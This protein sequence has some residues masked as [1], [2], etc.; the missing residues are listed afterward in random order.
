MTSHHSRDKQATVAPDGHGGISTGHIRIVAESD[1]LQ[2]R[3]FYSYDTS[4]MRKREKESGLAK[5]EGGRRTKEDLMSI[6]GS[7]RGSLKGE[8][9]IIILLGGSI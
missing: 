6:V 3:C 4:Y 9:G 2:G 8:S 1:V 5:E 7:G